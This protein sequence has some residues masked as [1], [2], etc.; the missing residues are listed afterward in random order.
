MGRDPYGSISRCGGV[1][2]SVGISATEKTE[3]VLIK[4]NLN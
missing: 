1:V 4:G 3:L 2:V